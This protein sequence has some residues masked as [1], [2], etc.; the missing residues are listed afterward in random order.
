[1][2][3]QIE[4]ESREKIEIVD[5]EKNVTGVFYWNPSDFDIVKRCEKV[6]EVFENLSIP[7]DAGDDAL[8]QLSNDIKK[9][10]DYLLNS[11]A[12]E[13]LFSKCNPLSPRPNGELYAEYVLSVLIK[14]IEAEMDVRLKKSTARIKK[15]TEKYEK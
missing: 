7:K 3:R 6:T 5:S 10:F 2:A 4:L 11:E 1:M 8:F 14:F 15:Y 12:S 9:Q 13:A